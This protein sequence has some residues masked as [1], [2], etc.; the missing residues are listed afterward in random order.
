MHPNAKPAT[1]RKRCN[2]IPDL[3]RRAWVTA[4][5]QT[6]LPTISHHR[7]EAHPMNPCNET[8]AAATSTPGHL[9]APIQFLAG[10]C[11]KVGTVNTDREGI[12]LTVRKVVKSNFAEGQE[13]SWI[14]RSRTSS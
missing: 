12:E 11:M 4:S 6:A 5:A 10:E 1:K 3:I 2:A 7:C 9:E 14:Q 13:G 8:A